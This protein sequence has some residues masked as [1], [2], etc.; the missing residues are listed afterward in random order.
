MLPLASNSL[1]PSTPQSLGLFRQWGA[2]MVAGELFY[3]MNA[4]RH[5]DTDYPLI[6]LIPPQ[7]L[8]APLIAF[9][10]LAEISKYIKQAST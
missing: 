7:K 5:G 9:P 8:K 4:L 3:H 2:S 1:L 6:V 10:G